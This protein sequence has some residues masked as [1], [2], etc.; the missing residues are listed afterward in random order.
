[1]GFLLPSSSL[2]ALPW[3]KLAG[4]DQGQARSTRGLH[5]LPTLDQTNGGGEEGP[6]LLTPFW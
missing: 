3:R 5:P 4:L 6:D 2:L 1:M